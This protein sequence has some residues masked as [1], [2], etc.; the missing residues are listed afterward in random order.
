MFGL[1]NIFNGLRSIP[2]WVADLMVMVANKFIAALGAVIGLIISVLPGFPPA[3]SPPEGPVMDAFVWLVPVGPIFAGMS[4]I[5][6]SFVI[7]LGYKSILK[8]SK[9]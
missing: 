4:A 2:F 9:T 7:F 5:T 6:T 3:P 8:W 1:D